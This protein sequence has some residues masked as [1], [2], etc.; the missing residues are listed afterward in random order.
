MNTHLIGGCG[1]D[2]DC[3]HPRTRFILF[4]RHVCTGDF[5]LSVGHP[6][7][8]SLSEF[9]YVCSYNLPKENAADSQLDCTVDHIRKATEWSVVPKEISIPI[10]TQVSGRYTL[11]LC[12]H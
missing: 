10:R 8:P 12:K 3:G 9:G 11:K 6:R 4:I 5:A 2:N 7:D 1:E